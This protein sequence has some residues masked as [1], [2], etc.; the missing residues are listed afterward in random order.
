MTITGTDDPTPPTLDMLEAV[1]IRRYVGSELGLVTPFVDYAS[2]LLLCPVARS[3]VTYWC[4]RLPSQ[5][6]GME[7]SGTAAFSDLML[8]QV[9]H[10]ILWGQADNLM[11]IPTDCD[12]R[13][14]RLGWTGDSALSSVEASLNY[15]M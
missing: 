2:P 9:Q 13:D 6:S 5:N 7:Q 4:P 15:D 3:L 11:M 12:N 8:N 1:N 14:E 10:N